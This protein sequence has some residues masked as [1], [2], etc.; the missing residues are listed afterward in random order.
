MISQIERWIDQTNTQYTSQRQSCTI[1]EKKFAGYFPADFLNS[2][3]FVVVETVPKPDLPQLRHMKAVVDFLDQPDDGI[4]YKN[5][6]YVA[7]GY[8]SCEALHFHELV[9]IA[10]WK[11][12]GETAFIQRYISELN[13][14]G[15]ASAPLE[16]MAYKLQGCF[17]K[18]QPIDI[19]QYVKQHL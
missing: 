16:D 4:T 11:E 6:Y 15:Y 18:S 19:L 7:R 3:Y 1:F 5:T 14:Y 12:L 17:E 13:N 2:S 9:H 8:E 10:Q